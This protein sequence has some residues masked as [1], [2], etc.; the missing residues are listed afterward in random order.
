MKKKLYD[1]TLYYYKKV[2]VYADSEQD[3]IEKA[4]MG[5]GESDGLCG[6]DGMDEAN[7]IDEEDAE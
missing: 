6:C 7:L 5:Y 1:V 2:E 3:A 4:H